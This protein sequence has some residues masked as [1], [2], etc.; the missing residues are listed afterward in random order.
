MKKTDFSGRYFITREPGKHK[1]VWFLYPRLNFKTPTACYIPCK[2]LLS[3]WERAQ[4]YGDL[5]PFIEHR[6][7][8]RSN[9][10]YQAYEWMKNLL[11]SRGFYGKKSEY[12]REYQDGKLIYKGG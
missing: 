6:W 8:L 7:F 4:N 10:D 2:V 3:T 12:L 5:K 9:K 1:F 11:T